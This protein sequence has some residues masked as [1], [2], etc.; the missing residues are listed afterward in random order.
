MN[1]V[2]WSPDGKRIASGGGDPHVP[3]ELN[4]FT[5]QTWD[6]TTGNHVHTYR[7]HTMTIYGVE[8][9]ST[10]KYI[11]S[12]SADDTIRIWNAV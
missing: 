2:S 9:S 12:G 3:P 7:G 5:I 6:A 11:G 8:W 4:D 10:G 1:A